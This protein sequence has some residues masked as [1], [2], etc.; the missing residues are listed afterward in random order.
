M[1]DIDEKVESLEEQMANEEAAA[2]AVEE[3]IKAAGADV[4]DKSSS[5]R[6]D[7][8]RRKA[9][10]LVEEAERLTSQLDVGSV[11]RSKLKVENE[12]GQ[13]TDEFNEVYV[14]NA[15]EDHKYI[16]IFRDPHNEYGGRFV[17]RMQA[18][19]WRVVGS[20]EETNEAFEHRHVDNTRVVADC[21]L[22]KIRLD[23]YVVL[24]K[25]DRLLREA[26]QA[27]VYAN[28]FDVA[29]QTGVRVWDQNDMPTEISQGIM[30]TAQRGLS[31]RQARALGAFHQ[32]NATG[33]YDR[34]LKEG[35]IPGLPP[36]YVKDAERV[37]MTRIALAGYRLA[38]AL[39]AAFDPKP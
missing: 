2:A 14:S 24:Q 19:G 25:R 26:Q 5:K 1:A 3:S 32:G 31:R 10:K 17:R 39:N 37:A 27:G 7:A 33:K 21:V 22:M 20:N 12:V 34:M 35:A 29:D 28:V 13:A 4:K 38:D 6:Q 36:G 8:I 23:R 18:L 16:W 30:Q 15:L 9:A 11:D